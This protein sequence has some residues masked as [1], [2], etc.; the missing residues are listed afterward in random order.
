MSWRM[1][2]Q[3]E[4]VLVARQL[5]G[6]LDGC[7]GHVAG[8]GVLQLDA[9]EAPRF[10]RRA[11]AGQVGLEPTEIVATLLDH[12]QHIHR[13]AARQRERERLHRRRPGLR[14]TVH[15]KG[16]APTRS[17]QHE[18]SLPYELDNRRRL[19][20]R[21]GGHGCI[22]VNSQL[23]TPKRPT[24]KLPIPNGPLPILNLQDSGPFWELEVGSWKLGPSERQK[25]DHAHTSDP[26]YCGR[27]HHD[28]R[29]GGRPRDARAR[30][31]VAHRRSR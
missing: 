19:G 31:A 12:V 28:E 11:C 26:S 4:Q 6:A 2:C 27:V 7:R 18:I 23:P 20:L 25:A 1:E 24:A 22:V 29:S 21:G 15:R 16:V 13:H 5:D 14:L 3:T 10:L 17:R 30:A 8:D 9:R